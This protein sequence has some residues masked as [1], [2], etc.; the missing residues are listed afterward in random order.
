MRKDGLEGEEGARSAIE[1][2]WGV[3]SVAVRAV[4]AA[5]HWSETNYTCDVVVVVVVSHPKCG[6]RRA[7]AGAE[8]PAGDLRGVVPQNENAS[9]T[10]RVKLVLL[11]D[12]VRTKP[13]E[14]QH[15]HRRRLPQHHQW[16]Q[17]L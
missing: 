15:K 9:G 6:S 12:S 17:Q 11:G 16:Q 7:Y 4:M 5:L 1:A 8:Q 3:P 13:A 14:M 2:E 10:P